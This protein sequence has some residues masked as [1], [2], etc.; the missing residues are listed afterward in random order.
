MRTVISTC[1]MHNDWPRIV[2]DLQAAGK[3]L[4]EIALECGFASASGVHD[5]KSGD[6]KTCSYERGVKLMEM[7]AKAVRKLAREAK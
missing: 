4:R 6:A 1:E 7:H 5:L 3:T 2:A